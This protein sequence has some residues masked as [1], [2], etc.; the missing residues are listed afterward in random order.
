MRRNQQPLQFDELHDELVRQTTNVSTLRYATT[1]ATA[2]RQSQWTANSIT[3]V[4]VGTSGTCLRE[5]V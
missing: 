2:D 4:G 3:P 1:S 5:P